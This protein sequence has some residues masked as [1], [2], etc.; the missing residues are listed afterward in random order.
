MDEMM[1]TTPKQGFLGGNTAPAL[2]GIREPVYKKRIPEER[3]F[4][5]YTEKCGT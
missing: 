3:G 2:E 4:L 1:N 5:F